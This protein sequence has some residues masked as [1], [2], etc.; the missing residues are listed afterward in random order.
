M[1]QRPSILPSAAGKIESL[2]IAYPGYMHQYSQKPYEDL[3]TI[4]RKK[5]R[6]IVELG[7][8]NSGSEKESNYAPESQGLRLDDPVLAEAMSKIEVRDISIE[9]NLDYK[10]LIHEGMLLLEHNVPFV[11]SGWAQDPFCVLRLDDTYHIILQ[12]YYSKRFADQYISFAL[13]NHEETAFFIKPTELQFEGGNILAGSDFI[14]AGKN[15]LANNCLELMRREGNVGIDEIA[16][17]SI[18]SRMAKEFGVEHVIWV[19]FQNCRPDL[20]ASGEA[21]YQPA[22]HIDLFLTLGGKYRGNTVE[23][24]NDKVSQH[25]NEQQQLI[26]IGDPLMAWQSSTIGT[27]LSE[28]SEQ[29]IVNYFDEIADFFWAFNQA[30]N[31]SAPSFKIVRLPLYIYKGIIFSYNN[32]LVETFDDQGNVYLPNYILSFP[33][34]TEEKELNVVLEQIQGQV[35]SIFY[36]NGFSSVNWIGKGEH[37]QRFAKRMGSLRCLTKVLRRSNP[38]SA[39]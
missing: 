19:G 13:A 21:T 10:R 11:H 33:S 12:S 36:G 25:Q 30:S 38:S 39:N 16:V 4:F 1:I 23:D 35:E 26:F 17:E 18:R 37:F 6:E 20:F 5:D 7:N 8:W 32:C 3:L 31:S 22:Y 2:L 27:G 14:L 9:F 29:E 28:N 34:N 24:F 15:I